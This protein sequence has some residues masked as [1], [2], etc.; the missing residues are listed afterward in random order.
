[1]AAM[2]NARNW[3][4][5]ASW[6]GADMNPSLTRVRRGALLLAG[7]LALSV[8]GYRWFG[9]SWLDSIYMVVITVS[10]IGYG[11]R[12]SLPPAE[13]V[14]TILV[15]LFGLTASAYTLGG[16]LQLLTQGEIEKALGTRR[17]IREISGLKQHVIV[18]GFGRMGRILCAE[19]H[20]SKVP[21]VV[22]DREL[23]IVAEIAA[24]GYLGYQGD[25][26]EEETL[27]AVGIEHAEHL[28]TVLPGDAD[29]VYITLTSRNL[30]P[31]FQII[32]RGELP[33]TQK[34]L[35]QAGATRV[36]LPAAIGGLRAASMITKPST[37]E[38]M[39][40]FVGKNV[41]DVEI[42]ELRLNAG[43]PLVGQMVSESLV[44]RRHGLLVVAVKRADGQMVFNPDADFSFLVGDTIVV[45]GKPH[46]I[47]R[48][49]E[50]NKL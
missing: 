3:L 32:A 27:R 19:L 18:C 12:T 45:M 29:N 42:D 9:R 25:A 34:K 44:R 17:M 20:R 15:I 16:F 26:T 4:L 28:V 33:S 36:I 41:L 40:L 21:F 37:V 43:C 14:F 46:D 11:E 39:E 30:N 8:G 1:M 48:F 2:H 47:K 10:T 49:C 22:V 7:V 23:S 13:Q 38:L 35:M 5:F 50:E 6:I 31:K 24:A